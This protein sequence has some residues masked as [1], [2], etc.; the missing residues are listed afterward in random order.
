MDT[1]S[2]DAKRLYPCGKCRFLT[3]NVSG[4]S[5]TVYTHVL[6]CYMPLIAEDTFEKFHLGLGVFSMQGFKRRNKESKEEFR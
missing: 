5:E 3:R 2:R 4:D 6:K 1:F